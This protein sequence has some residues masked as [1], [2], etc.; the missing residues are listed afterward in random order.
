MDV[1]GTTEAYYAWGIA[2]N[3]RAKAYALW[4]GLKIAKVLGVQSIIVVQDSNTI[5]N[6]MV[7]NSRPGNY[8]LASILDRSKQAACSF[9]SINF[10]HVL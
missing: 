1:G 5:I 4:Q 3:N 7:H 8:P 9:S 2:S 10:D 6:H